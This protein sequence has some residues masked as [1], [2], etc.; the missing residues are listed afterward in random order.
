M[1]KLSNLLLVIVLLLSFVVTTT[2][3]ATDMSNGNEQIEN[4]EVP[5]QDEEN[6]IGED[7]EQDTT[8]IEWTDVSNVTFEWQERISHSYPR[9]QVNNL[10]DKEDSRFYM[11]VSNTKE[12][13]DVSSIENLDGWDE[14]GWVNVSA[15]Y[16]T[17]KDTN[18]LIEKNDKIYVWLAESIYDDIAMKRINK[19]LIDAKEI[20][21]PAQLSLGNRLKAYFFNDR[22]S[23]FCYEPISEGRKENIQINYKIG[24]ITDN[25]ILRSIQRG[26]SDCLERLMEYAKSAT[27]GKTG[28]VKLGEDNS[29]TNNLGL[30]NDA[31]YYAY[32]ELDD[33]NGEYYPVEDVSLYQALVSENVG[34]NLFDYLS[35]EFKWNINDD[36]GDITPDDDKDNNNNNNSN[37]N[38]GKDDEKD[39]TTAPGKIPQTG[40]TITIVATLLIIAVTGTIVFIKYRK[41][42]GIK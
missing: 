19:I 4:T 29:I 9:L 20:E 42:R 28:S 6:V 2:S 22:T 34:I 39:E 41:M 26:D 5:S 10:I 7:E 30:V 32:M 18:D 15:D 13:I 3:F 1:K 33:G 14:A 38:D 17:Y 8:E 27:N 16:N 37:K 35:N 24:T 25:D 40:A 11:Y 36:T 31:Y 12:N 23:T 21:R